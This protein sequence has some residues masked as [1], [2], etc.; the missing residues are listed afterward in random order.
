[1]TRR[2]AVFLSAL[3]AAGA[4]A[5][6]APQPA[7]AIESCAFEGTATT[8][9]PL[10][11]P[12][13][14]TSAQTTFAFAFNIGTCRHIPSL[15]A[16]KTITATGSVLGW[17]G[18]SS[19]LGTT[20][21]GDLFAWIGAGGVLEITGHTNGSATVI[22]DVLVGESCTTGADQFIVTGAVVL[23][24]CSS[25][26]GPDVDELTGLP[27]GDDFHLFTNSPCFP[28]ML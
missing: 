27:N 25:L 1:M 5:V 6:P 9:A 11:Y 2:M 17:C 3:L 10:T 28:S 16:S 19:G 24:N 21:N 14:S 7:G 8:G 4:W 18:L 12:G 26:L 20:G 13:F 23:N 15:T 22:P